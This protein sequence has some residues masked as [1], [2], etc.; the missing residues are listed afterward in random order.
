M[1]F[2][3]QF[4]FL[5]GLKDNKFSIKISQKKAVKAKHPFSLI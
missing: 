1:E 3:N 5:Q 4:S 2:N